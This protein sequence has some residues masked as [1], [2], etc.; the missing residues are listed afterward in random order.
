[1]NETLYPL[2]PIVVV[3]DEAQVLTGYDM[4][5]RYGGFDN[6]VT[7]QD[8]REIMSLLAARTAEVLVLDLLMPHLGGEALLGLVSREFPSIPVIVVT[9]VDDVDTAVRCM[10]LGAFDYLVKPIDNDR[11][12]TTVGRA[13]AFQELERENRFLKQSLLATDLKHP[14]V[15]AEMITRDQAMLSIFRYVEAVAV[16]SKPV[17]ITG[18]TGVGKEL[19][20]R[21][22]HRVSGRTGAFIGAN[23]AGLDDTLFADTLFG[24]TRGAFT[25]ADQRRRGLIEKAAGGTLLLDEI[26]DL[27]LASQMKLLR[28]LQENEYLPLGEDIPIQ[29]NTRIVASTNRDIHCFK[30]ES[31]FRK[32][33]FYR[34]RTHHIHVPPLR[35][36][37]G[38]IP[39]L[40][41]HFL[42]KAALNLGKKIP[43]SP[44]ELMDLMSVYDFPGNIREL[45]AMA[46]DAVARHESGVLGMTV[47]KSYILSG[48]PAFEATQDRENLQAGSCIR[49]SERLPTIR[50]TTGILIEE[51]LRRSNGNI[52]IA[53]GLLGISHQA[54]RKR[55]KGR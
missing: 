32:D 38:D 5:L 20:A 22:V 44:P 2:S 47:F 10:K 19:I 16:T 54:L 26:G 40:M 23:V 30:E 17:L 36:R 1:M 52:A 49:F 11:L 37:G 39:L 31:R 45:E 41:D 46:Y 48:P 27:S 8:S 25:G 50:A 9:G 7:C 34:L 51:A 35:E 55:L 29:A 53:A 21:A 24:H 6:I 14:E 3:D 42:Q 43:T 4:A 33:L 12:V 18:E 15:F 13:I 28:L